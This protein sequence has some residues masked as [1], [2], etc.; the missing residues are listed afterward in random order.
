ML[1]LHRYITDN[2]KQSR[3]RETGRKNIARLITRR[4]RLNDRSSH[5]LKNPV[6]R[7]HDAKRSRHCRASR[8]LA[9]N[10]RRPGTICHLRVWLVILRRISTRAFAHL[11]EFAV[12]G[13]MGEIRCSA[14]QCRSRWIRS[15]AA[16]SETVRMLLP[17]VFARN[18]ATRKTSRDGSS[19]KALARLESIFRRVCPN[20]HEV[21]LFFVAQQAE[22]SAQ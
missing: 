21:H 16:R 10:E 17:A 20:L 2:T 19:G 3:Q 4:S 15:R 18:H 1:L 13:G 6:K 12:D 7:N 22:G 9:F 14:E 11:A 8:A 5:S